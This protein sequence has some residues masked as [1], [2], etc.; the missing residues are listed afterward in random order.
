MPAKE[1][2]ALAKIDAKHPEFKTA[3]EHW[4]RSQIIRLA[5]G[6]IE[7]TISG[8][9]RLRRRREERERQSRRSAD[10]ETLPRQ[11]PNRFA[12]LWP[13]LPI[14]SYTLR[15]VDDAASARRATTPLMIM[16]SPITDGN[17]LY[18]E[19]RLSM[20]SNVR[21]SKVCTHRPFGLCGQSR[22]PIAQQV[23]SRS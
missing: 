3:D 16:M 5:Q 15:S 12:L 9:L 8:V 4:H 6:E 14:H 18:P 21:S 22:S 23:V 10:H 17:S 7:P 2:K 20:S 19:E 1:A 11:A 13:L